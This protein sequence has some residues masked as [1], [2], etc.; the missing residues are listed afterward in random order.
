MPALD[1]NVFNLES[2]DSTGIVPK[3]TISRDETMGPHRS[4]AMM[5]SPGQMKGTHT[6]TQLTASPNHKRPLRWAMTWAIYNIYFAAKRRQFDL[7]YLFGS[8]VFGWRAKIKLFCLPY[9][10]LIRVY[11]VSSAH[12]ATAVRERYCMISTIER[13]RRNF[14]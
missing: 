5:P 14:N 9:C 1:C 13:D 4:K 6:R 3:F 12:L 11:G 10:G 8:N 2:H 7:F